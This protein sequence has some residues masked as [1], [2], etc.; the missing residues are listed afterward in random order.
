MFSIPGGNLSPVFEL[1]EGV[2]DQMPKF[3]E[4]LV[5][6]SGRG[7]VLAW[8]NHHVHALA[9]G[10]LDNRLAVVAFIRNQMFCRDPLH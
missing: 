9:G 4:T 10:L 8:Q 7:S 1:Q 6:L 3:I 2:L 5:V